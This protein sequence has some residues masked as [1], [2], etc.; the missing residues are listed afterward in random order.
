MKDMLFID[1][2]VLIVVIQWGYYVLV[3][4]SMMDVYMI[5]TR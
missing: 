2:F 3:R 1:D 4:C 5:F